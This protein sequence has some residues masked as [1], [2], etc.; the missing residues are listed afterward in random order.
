MGNIIAYFIFTF[1]FGSIAGMYIVVSIEKM[2]NTRFY[3][4][5]YKNPF[6]NLLDRG[7]S[8]FK[9]D[10][11]WGN[12]VVFV[13]DTNKTITLKLHTK[14]FYVSENGEAKYM[15]HR[16]IKK[17]S[18]DFFDKITTMFEKEIYKDVTTLNDVIVSSKL[19][20]TP[21]GMD[22]LLNDLVKE[23]ELLSGNSPVSLSIQE[24]LD[25]LLEKITASGIDSLTEDER[26]RIK[27]LEK[28]IKD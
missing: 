28:I 18:D 26:I 11:R 9:F 1:I 12:Y 6:K 10:Y 14:E 27:E 23:E 17:E 20:I 19:V 4:K 13:F 25:T 22:T 5:H 21:K 2:S 24:Q 3:E 15:T 7:M 16:S 8:I